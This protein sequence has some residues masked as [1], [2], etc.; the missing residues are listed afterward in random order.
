MAAPNAPAFK[1][2]RLAPALATKIYN[3]EADIARR[4]S[5]LPDREG[6]S[7]RWSLVQAETEAFLAAMNAKMDLIEHIKGKGFRSQ[8]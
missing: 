5:R 6:R 7:V 4:R 8:L 2:P 3:L 1:L